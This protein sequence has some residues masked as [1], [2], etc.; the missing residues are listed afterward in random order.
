MN[1]RITEHILRIS[2][3]I[4]EFMNVEKYLERI[5]LSGKILGLQ[6]YP[7]L[8]LLQE[9][10][11]FSVPY[12]NLDVIDGIPISLK[13]EDVYDKIVTRHRGGFC[14]EL[15]AL[16]N[17]LLRE[18]GFKTETYFARFWRGETGIPLRRHRVIA[19][20]S[21]DKTYILDVGIGA[22]APRIPLLLEK[23]TVQIYFGESYK[24]GYSDEFGWVLYELYHGE[25]REYFSFTEEKQM[26]NDFVAI[27]YYCE[28]HPDSKFNKNIMVAI[29]T[30]DGRS[31]IDGNVFKKFS[32]QS[33]S[34]IEEDLSIDRLNEI[35]K[36][37]FGI[38]RK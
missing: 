33:L 6:G 20:F 16:F 10:H 8:K 1:L 11:I 18:L 26:E 36:N 3:L 14:F 31:S 5:G 2:D 25:W 38:E 17:S 22:V 27:S 9:A 7:L 19:V 4:G 12:E 24:F 28:K 29:K 23:D 30:P 21:D 37:E 35:L 15:N 34:Y 13:L 32:G